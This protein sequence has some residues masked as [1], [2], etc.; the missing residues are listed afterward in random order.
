MSFKDQT[1]LQPIIHAVPKGTP[2]PN[3]CKECLRNL[4]FIA[5]D[6][7]EKTKKDPSGRSHYRRPEISGRLCPMPIRRQFINYKCCVGGI[8]CRSYVKK[9]RSNYGIA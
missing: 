7:F 3:Y 8:N 2:L 6:Q 5:I 4:K 1:K 9:R